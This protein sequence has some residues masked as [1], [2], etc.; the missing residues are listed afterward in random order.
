M[1]VDIFD[2]VITRFTIG[3]QESVGASFPVLIPDPR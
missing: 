3:G 2:V 1:P